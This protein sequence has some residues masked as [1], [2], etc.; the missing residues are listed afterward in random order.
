M[1]DTTQAKVD[2]RE[3]VLE[4]WQELIKRHDGPMDTY[5]G[6]S[7]ANYLVLHRSLIQEMPSEWQERLVT[8]LDDYWENWDAVADRDFEVR[9]RDSHGRWNADP[10]ANYRHASRELMDSLRRLPVDAADGE[11]A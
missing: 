7:R 10:L 8:L 5:F 4:P 9:V 1:N 2:S 3:R 6:L 11:G